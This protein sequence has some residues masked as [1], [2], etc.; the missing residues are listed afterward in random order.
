MTELDIV[1]ECWESSIIGVS[2]S[3]YIQQLGVHPFHVVFYTEQQLRLYVNA[4]R[5][6]ATVLHFDTTGSIMSKIPGRKR[7]QC[8]CLLIAD[9][10]FL[11]TTAGHPDNETL[12][13]LAV[14]LAGHVQ[15]ICMPR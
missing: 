13:R 7:P 3:G 10:S 4:C 6:T 2:I 14:Q 15:R 1:P 11:F 5:S 9:T 12:Q 8:Y